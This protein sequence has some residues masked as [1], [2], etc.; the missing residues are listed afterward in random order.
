MALSVRLR[1]EVFKRDNFTC[2]YC[3]RKS[4]EVVL[5]ADHIVPRSDGGS[6]DEMNLVTSCWE[7]NRGKSAVP[8]AVVM[9]GDEPHDRAIELLEKKRQLE[10]YNAVIAEDRATRED[11]AWTLVDYWHELG[12]NAEKEENGDLKIGKR[13]FNWLFTALSWCPAQ[14]I[15]DFMDMAANRRMTRNLAYVA[16]CCRNWRYEQA[17][18]QPAK[19]SDY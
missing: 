11:A 5:E 3:G 13:D 14:M 19:G 7:C 17:A 9:T 1:F 15:R 10:E 16:A 4:P 18:Q 8:L 12:G 2:R 6:D